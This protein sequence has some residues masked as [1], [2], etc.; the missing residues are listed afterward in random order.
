MFKKQNNH[1][2]TSDVYR[3]RTELALSLT[4]LSGVWWFF[5]FNRLKRY[6]LVTYCYVVGKFC[7]GK[8]SRAWRKKNVLRNKWSLFISVHDFLKY[9]LPLFILLVWYFFH[10]LVHVNGSAHVNINIFIYLFICDVRINF[11]FWRLKTTTKL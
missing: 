7:T 5:C 9:T 8:V 11:S 1:F 2:G 3:L 4:I 6:R 10:A